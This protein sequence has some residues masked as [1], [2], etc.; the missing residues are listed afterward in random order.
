MP[1]DFQ[2]SPTISPAR[3]LPSHCPLNS[4]F[5]DVPPLSWTLLAANFGHHD[6]WNQLYQF[7]TNF[8]PSLSMSSSKFLYLDFYRLT[9]VITYL[10]LVRF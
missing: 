3:L 1:V 4:D 6:E 10:S 8:C 5:S 7:I 9:E 2:T